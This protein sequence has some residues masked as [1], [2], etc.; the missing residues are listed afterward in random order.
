MLLKVQADNPGCPE[1]YDQ[2]GDGTQDAVC[3]GGKR[4]NGFYGFGIVNALDAVTK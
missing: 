3:K 4:V 1:S 2:N